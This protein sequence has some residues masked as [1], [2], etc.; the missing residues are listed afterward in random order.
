MYTLQVLE[1]VLIKLFCF[2]G[3]IV[4]EYF[5]NKNRKINMFLII[6]SL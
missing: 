3:T 6:P 5:L 1:I 4:K 2:M